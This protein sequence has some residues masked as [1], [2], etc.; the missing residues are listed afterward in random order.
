MAK[1]KRSRAKRRLVLDIGSRAV[2][3]CELSQTKTGLQ[4][5]KYLQRPFDIDPAMEEEEKRRIRSDVV[6]DLLKESKVRAKKTIFG[7]PGQSIFNRTRAL[8]PVPEHKVTQIVRYEIQQQIPFS[9][10]QIAFDYQVLQRTEAGGYDVL[11]AAIKVDVV[12]KHLAILQDIKRQVDTVDVCPLA[13]YNWLKHTGEFGEEGECVAFIDLGAATTDIVIERGN[14]FR[15]ARPLSIGGDTITEGISKAFGMSFMDAERLKKERGFAPTGDPR[16]DGKGGEV[17]GQ[18]LS[19]LVAEITRT[20]AYFRSQPGGGPVSRVVVAG[21]GACLRNIVPYLQRELGLEVRIAQ[22]LSGLAVGPGAQEV[23][24]YPEQACVVLGLALRCCQTVPVEI[25]LIPPRITEGARRR[26]QALYWILSGITLAFILASII[27]ANAHKHEA[28]RKEIEEVERVIGLYDAGL[29]LS[30]KQED[31]AAPE[32][33]EAPDPTE[34][35]APGAD[36][37]KTTPKEQ[38]SDYELEL[39]E[40]KGNVALQAFQLR[41]LNDIQENRPD[42]IEYLVSIGEAR[43]KGKGVWFS[44]VESC[45]IRPRTEGDEASTG[46]R[47]FARAAAENRTL[48]GGRATRG[49]RASGE[50]QAAE[51]AREPGIAVEGFTGIAPAKGGGEA[52]LGGVGLGRATRSGSGSDQAPTQ[53]AGQPKNPNG[54]SIVGYAQDPESIWEFVENLKE[55][56]AFPHG[57]HFDESTANRV[58]PTVLN[59]AAVGGG[60]TGGASAGGAVGGGALRGRTGGG[61]LRG[62]AGRTGFGARGMPAAPPMGRSGTLSS[63]APQSTLTSFR[64]QVQFAKTVQPTRVAA[65]RRSTSSGQELLDR[66]QQQRTE[67]EAD[68]APEGDGEEE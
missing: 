58:P 66:M 5:T 60:P 61:G 64:I 30:L 59:N 43:P 56:G 4:L 50:G 63:L 36:G 1:V 53:R 11:M 68:A 34:A 23:N 24:E 29:L 47:G 38:K 48:G 17:I 39:E 65:P 13:A 28:L 46:S 32:T 7:L 35:N 51:S 55:G 19:R 20:F 27:P 52:T 41:L 3:L 10:D 2:R 31:L 67:G 57:V 45:V 44:A 40:A 33:T 54:L 8:P 62:L 9:L 25:N 16:R 15:F 6:K 14:Q 26:E 49:D 22:P 21:G 18:S 42:W 12:E 37:L